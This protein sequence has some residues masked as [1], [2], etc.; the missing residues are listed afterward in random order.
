MFSREG[1]LKAT[2]A[3]GDPYIRDPKR[4]VGHTAQITSVKWAPNDKKAFYTASYD[5][6]IRLWNVE[7]PRKHVWYSFLSNLSGLYLLNPRFQ[8]VELRLLPFACHKIQE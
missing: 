3:K 8:D 6:T 5:S 2:F 4:T 1:E 7:D